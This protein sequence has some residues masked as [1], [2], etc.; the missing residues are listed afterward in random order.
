MN[1]PICK[2]E[3]RIFCLCGYCKDCINKLGH[4]ECMDIYEKQKKELKEGGKA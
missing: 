4:T 3:K 2:K 1:C